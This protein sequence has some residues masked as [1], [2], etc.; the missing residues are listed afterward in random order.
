VI[1]R[2]TSGSAQFQPSATPPAPASTPSEASPSV[3]ACSPSATSAA[4]PILRPVLIR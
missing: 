3:R 2:P 1:A 4:D